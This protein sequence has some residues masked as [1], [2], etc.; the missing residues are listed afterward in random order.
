MRQLAHIYRS[1]VES[2]REFQLAREMFNSAIALLGAYELHHDNRYYLQPNLQNAS[3]DI[4]AVKFTE[5]VEGVVLEVSQ[6]ELVEMNDYSSTNDV[7]NFLLKTKL[8]SRKSYDSKTIILC[9][10]NKEIPV[11]SLEISME[12][13]KIRSAST[14]YIVGKAQGNNS[15]WVIFSPYPD[16]IK[17]VIYN[18]T[19]T[20]E[21]YDLPSPMML[22][23]KIIKKIL[24]VNAS[25][26]PTSIYDIFNL[27]EERLK[28]YLR[29]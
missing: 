9:V 22:R 24:Y 1:N 12:L 4:V 28:K 21:K 27:K 2:K 26:K 3:P 8:S 11:N 25:P 29:T 10:V 20:M 18:I 14:I 6:L 15:D 16:L 23:R 7:V 19:K 13:K 17:P 5:S